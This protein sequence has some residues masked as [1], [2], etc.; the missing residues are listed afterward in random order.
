[1]L[2]QIP[3]RIQIVLHRRT[4]TGTGWPVCKILPANPINKLIDA[5][6]LD[7]SACRLMACEFNCLHLSALYTAKGIFFN[8]Q[9]ATLK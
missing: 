9:K 3:L 5:A 4:I 2:V 6:S 8:I 1:M 7:T